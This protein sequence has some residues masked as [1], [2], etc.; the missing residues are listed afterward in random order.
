ME[1]IRP[2]WPRRFLAVKEET[3]RTQSPY[4][5]QMGDLPA[6]CQS[7][8]RGQTLYLQGFV[9]QLMGRR[10]VEYDYGAFGYLRIVKTHLVH[11][12]RMCP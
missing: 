6:A 2:L 3:R 5:I 8:L 7:L 10:V 12:W 4:M 9:K 11:P 1:L